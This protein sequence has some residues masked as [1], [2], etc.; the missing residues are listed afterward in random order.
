MQQQMQGLIRQQSG[1]NYDN[2]ALQGGD[3]LEKDGRQGRG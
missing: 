3:V 1:L 2:L